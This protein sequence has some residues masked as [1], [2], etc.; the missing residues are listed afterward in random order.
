MS[1]V[2]I[3]IDLRDLTQAHFDECAPVLGHSHNTAPCIIGTLMTP[4]E[5]NYRPFASVLTLK[6]DGIL[7]IPEDQISD[8]LDL[9]RAFDQ[10]R[11]DDLVRIAGKYM[12]KEAA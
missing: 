3:K 2:K 10:S 1:E 5:R 9:Q 4:D 12:N 11:W 7:E 6:S 8:A